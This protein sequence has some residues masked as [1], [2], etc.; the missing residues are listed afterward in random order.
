[1]KKRLFEG[2]EHMGLGSPLL[3]CQVSPSP[4]EVPRGSLVVVVV[5]CVLCVGGAGWRRHRPLEAWCRDN[6]LF[7]K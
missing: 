2:K 1:M 7:S 3:D 5:W 4:C 6:V